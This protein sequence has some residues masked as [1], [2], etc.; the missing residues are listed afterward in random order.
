MK[1]TDTEVETKAREWKQLRQDQIA[2]TEEEVKRV[3]AEMTNGRM[4]FTPAEIIVLAKKV[5]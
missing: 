3:E 1:K 5:Q 2:S 4:T